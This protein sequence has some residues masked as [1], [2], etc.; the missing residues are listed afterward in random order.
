[1]HQTKLLASLQYNRLN[2]KVVTVNQ[3]DSLKN[4]CSL[5]DGI[6]LK[7]GIPIYVTLYALKSAV[8]TLMFSRSSNWF[9]CER[10]LA[11][12][13]TLNNRHRKE[14]NDSNFDMLDDMEGVVEKYHEETDGNDE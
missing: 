6:C 8:M 14:T 7:D 9:V 12:L 13:L 4:L 5:C 11:A 10:L 2:G 1:M 3:S